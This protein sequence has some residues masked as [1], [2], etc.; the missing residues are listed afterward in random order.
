MSLYNRQICGVGRCTNHQWQ[1]GRA[2]RERRTGRNEPG[3]NL[4]RGRGI[5]APVR[6]S[7]S[8]QEC[9]AYCASRRPAAACRLNSSAMISRGTPHSPAAASSP[10]IC[11]RSPAIDRKHRLG[12][13]PDRVL[14]SGEAGHCQLCRRA[15]SGSRAIDGGGSLQKP[16][17]SR[18]Q[19]EAQ[20]LPLLC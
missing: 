6:V 5:E 16:E 19:E 15:S 4:I 14:W 12:I 3:A 1:S 9:L 17:L 20:F 10:T 11:R 18:M 13:P 7:R 8:G 2:P